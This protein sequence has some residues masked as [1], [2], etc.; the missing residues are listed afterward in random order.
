[1]ENSK[2][3]QFINFNL[4]TTLSSCDDT[5]RGPLG[6]AWDVSH[7]SVQS[8]RCVRSPPVSH[9]AAFAVIR[10]PVAVWQ[11]L[12]SSYPHLT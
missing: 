7:P 10:A 8:P 12:S 3:N 2:N 9:L 1:M 11:Y 6:P 4:R 5:A